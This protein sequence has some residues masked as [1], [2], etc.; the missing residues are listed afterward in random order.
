VSSF[1]A[2]K[3]G[4]LKKPG[5]S[6]DQEPSCAEDHNF[7]VRPDIATE[8]LLLHDGDILVFLLMLENKPDRRL[9]S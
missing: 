4:F 7:S 5:F 8:P 2:Q 1:P 3:P 9:G 6:I